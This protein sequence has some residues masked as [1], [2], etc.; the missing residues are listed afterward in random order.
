MSDERRWAIHKK[1]P[2]TYERHFWCSRD[3]AHYIMHRSVGPR[4]NS[5]DVKDGDEII[6]PSFTFSSTANAFLLRGARPV[7]VDCRRD[8]L[9]I[10]ENLIEAAVT[11]KTRAIAP[12][13]YAGVGCEM[14]AISTI[15]QKHRLIV[16]E[17]AAQGV[18]AK[19]K[20]R[21]L[22]TIGDIGAYSFTKRRILFAAKVGQLF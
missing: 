7:F 16:I 22:G 2:G 11:A 18:N 4:C 21:Y 14:D 8:T 9:N 20:G 12:V 3:F 5:A 19:Y 13:H 10:D 15:A 1:S 17:D 6:L